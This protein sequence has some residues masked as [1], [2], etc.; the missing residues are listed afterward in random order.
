VIYPATAFVSIYREVYVVDEGAPLP[1]FEASYQG[2]LGQDD[3]SVITSFTVDVSPSYNG[4]AGVYIL[5]PAATADNYIFTPINGTMYVNP[6]GPGTKQV[7]P[8]F[9]CY[10]ELSEPDSNGFLYLAHF[11]YENK[12]PTPVYIPIGPDNE[13][14]G[15][16][17]NNINQPE[18]FLPGGGTL[19][20]PYDGN[21]LRWEVT[22]NKNNGSK[23][24]IPANSSNTQCN[25]ST[26]AEAPGEVA[27]E[28]IKE[29]TIYP[30]PTTGKIFV[31]FNGLAVEGKDVSVIDIYGNRCQVGPVHSSDYQVE[32]DLTGLSSG[33]YLIRVNDDENSEVFRV[34]KR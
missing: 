22:S 2:F 27:G 34:V 23:G 26:E 5:I 7:K 10:E 20:V 16:S 15:V 18:I 14:T 12:N 9:L 28:D 29:V 13:M 33:L 17:F 30:N 1:S 6:A 3:E 31:Q 24:A 4:T 21:Q 32:I 25:K 19:V 11:E 8:I